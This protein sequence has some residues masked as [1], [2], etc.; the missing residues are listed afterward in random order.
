MPRECLPDHLKCSKCMLEKPSS[1]FYARKNSRAGRNQRCKE[2]VNIFKRAWRTRKSNPLIR[3]CSWC[4]AEFIVSRKHRTACNAEC[5]YQAWFRD[6]Y[7]P[8]NPLK[9]KRPLLSRRYVDDVGYIKILGNGVTKREHVI[10]AEAALGRALK[11]G[12]VVHHINGIK[13]DNRNE[14]LLICTAHYHKQLHHR[15][16]QLY[17]KEHF[18]A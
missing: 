9:P 2:C 1:D 5:R 6:V 14:N 3:K 10:K 17:Q 16:A 15:M 7:R 8:K 13:A 12:E 11:K 4:K 18:G